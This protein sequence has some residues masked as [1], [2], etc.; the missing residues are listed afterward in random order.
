MCVYVYVHVC[1]RVHV[2]LLLLPLWERNGGPGDIE[3]LP[4]S[5]I[6]YTKG[7][8][9]LYSLDMKYANHLNSK[10]RSIEQV[11]YF[12]LSVQLIFW[13]KNTKMLMTIT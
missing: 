6:Q 12:F 5:F 4:S 11:P 3:S 8:S 13:E 2:C 1:V 10:Q 7:Q 9:L